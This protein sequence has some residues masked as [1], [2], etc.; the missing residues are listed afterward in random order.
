MEMK[1]QTNLPKQQEFTNNANTQTMSF[2]T[3]PKNR[4]SV[5]NGDKISHINNILEI[6]LGHP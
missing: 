2:K 5:R 1:K 6:N 3:T 4:N